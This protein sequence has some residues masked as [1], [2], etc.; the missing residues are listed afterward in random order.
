VRLTEKIF[1]VVRRRFP[2]FKMSSHPDE[3]PNYLERD[4]RLLAAWK[5]G[6]QEKGEELLSY[7]CAL[8]HSLCD[9]AGIRS[10]HDRDDLYQDV[11]YA[12]MKSLPRL[13]IAVSFGGYMEKVF[14]RVL[15]RRKR[16]GFSSLSRDYTDPVRVPDN[17]EGEE[18]HHAILNCRKGLEKREA[19]VFKA[20]IFQRAPFSQI[21]RALGLDNDHLYVILYRAKSKMQECLK[22]KGFGLEYDR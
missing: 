15:V 4:R 20:R 1:P 11:V 14:F 6:D 9:D 12:I 22:K 19:Y 13:E 2:G 8:F 21:A 7:Y 5:A 18:F 16:A 3:R 10:K 17:V